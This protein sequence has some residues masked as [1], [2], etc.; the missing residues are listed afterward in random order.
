MDRKVFKQQFTL[1]HTPDWE[2]PTCKKGTL[3]IDTKTF[4]KDEIQSSRFHDYEGWDPEYIE[5]VYSTLLRCSNAVCKET[6]AST[7]VGSVGQYYSYDE[8]GETDVEYD[9]FFKPRYF[10]PPLRVL[11]PPEQTPP[12]VLLLLEESFRLFFS[13]P[14]ASLNQVRIATE[15]LLTE[16]GIKR[17]EVKGKKR[18]ALSLHARIGLLPAKYA[19]F[20]EMIFA[21]KWLGNA[22]SHAPAE[23]NEIKLDDVLDAYEFLDHVLQELYSPKTLGALKKK[24]QQ[25]NKKKGPVKK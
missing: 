1:K 14:S 6:V 25:V 9:D 11:N 12:S 16:L 10:E 3:K 22:G 24:A 13:S 2:C 18:F 20:K 4:H 5:F 15:Q 7:G 19:G 23:N 8:H 17:F 21:I